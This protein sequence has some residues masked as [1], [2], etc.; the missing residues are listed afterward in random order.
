MTSRSIQYA[1]FAMRCGYNA[2]LDMPIILDW[3]L[4]R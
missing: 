4:D 3:L 2:A 1:A